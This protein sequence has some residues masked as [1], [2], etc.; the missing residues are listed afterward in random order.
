MRQVGAARSDRTKKRTG[1][2]VRRALAHRE[3]APV[4]DTD[5]AA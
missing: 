5:V 2:A 1:S 3:G 4:H